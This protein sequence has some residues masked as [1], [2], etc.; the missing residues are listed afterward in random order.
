MCDY[1]SSGQKLNI[2]TKNV[3]YILN[4]EKTFEKYRNGFIIE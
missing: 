4:I 1:D 2:G 3:N